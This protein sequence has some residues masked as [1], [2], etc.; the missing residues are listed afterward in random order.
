MSINFYLFEL[1]FPCFTNVSNDSLKIFFPEKL[2]IRSI[3]KCFLFLEVQYRIALLWGFCF[4]SDAQLYYLWFKV[5]LC[6]PPLNE[7]F[8]SQCIIHHIFFS[9]LSV[10]SFTTANLLSWAG[11]L[12]ESFGH[13]EWPRIY[14]FCCLK[15]LIFF[16]CYHSI[17]FPILT[18]KTFIKWDIICDFK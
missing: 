4:L 8:K 7:N 10:S 1:R 13:G 14:T 3:T 9:L 15:P 16:I 12:K 17:P 18:N 5:K 2:I 11:M 6:R